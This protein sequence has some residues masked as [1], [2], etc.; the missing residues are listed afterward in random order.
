MFRLLVKGGVMMAGN[1]IRIGKTEIVQAIREL[2]ERTYGLTLQ[3]GKGIRKKYIGTRL[4]EQPIVGFGSADD[5]L[6]EKYKETG[7]IGPWHMSPEEWL[8]GARSIVSV[9]LPFSEEVLE[10]NRKMRVTG[11]RLWSYAR[12]EGQAYIATLTRAVREWLIENGINACAPCID[13]RFAQL[14][15]GRGNISGYDEID[16]HTFGSRW[17]ERHTAYVCGLGTFGL[18]KGLIT[19]KGIAGRFTSFIIDA[20]L[21]PDKRPYE[22]LYDY[23][24]RCGACIKR[25]P[26]GAITLEKGKDH[27][28]C[29]G[30]INV[31][32]VIHYPRYG[33]GLCQTAVPCERCNPNP[34]FKYL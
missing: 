9:F 3:D 26:A 16:E 32:G 13:E 33:C 22:G 19:D 1:D 6:Y 25:C 7:V 24:I 27:N 5:S 30:C 11:S 18:S 23:C 20:E 28:I 34:A 15:A 10:S 12:V 4:Y 14:Q 2:A 21:E 8:P 17:S 29:F 31:S